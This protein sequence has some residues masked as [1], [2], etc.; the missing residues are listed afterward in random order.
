M[1]NIQFKKGNTLG[2]IVIAGL[3]CALSISLVI[4]CS[5]ELE[6]VIFPEKMDTVLR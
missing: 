4:S 1:A 5:Q 3:V 6:Q 2:K